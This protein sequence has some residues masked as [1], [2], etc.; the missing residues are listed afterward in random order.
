MDNLL[1][2][3]FHSTTIRCCLK[4]GCIDVD[5]RPRFDQRRRKTP[6]VKLRPYADVE[7]ASEGQRAP[8]MRIVAWLNLPG[9]LS[10]LT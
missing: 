2:A 1:R 7:Y 5:Q 3:S 4:I 6:E 8:G 10:Y 9:L